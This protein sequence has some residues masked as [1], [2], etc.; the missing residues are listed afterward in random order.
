[1]IALTSW[2][3]IDRLLVLVMRDLAQAQG[4]YA[5]RRVWQVLVLALGGGVA[6][7]AVLRARGLL[8]SADAATRWAAAGVILVTLVALLRLVSLHAT[9][10]WLQ[11]RLAG[12][13]AGRWVEALGLCMTVAG[14]VRTW[15]VNGR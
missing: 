15:P 6:L 12:L 7:V 4:W 9:D 10:L 11:A 2:L 5:Q 14:V 8:A 13:S 3:A 1:M